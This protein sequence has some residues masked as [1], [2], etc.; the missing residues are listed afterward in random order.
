MQGNVRII[1]PSGFGFLDSDETRR[2]YYFHASR[3]VTPF[4]DLR[5]LDPVE[6]NVE[7]D[8]RGG[9]ADVAVNIQRIP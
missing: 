4:D 6:F 5:E 2:R 3:C 7:P 1:K 8:L 9:K